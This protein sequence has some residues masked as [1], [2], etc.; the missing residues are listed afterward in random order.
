L[1][2][3]GPATR[4]TFFATVAS[5]ASI[6]TLPFK[7]SAAAIPDE[8]IPGVEFAFSAKVL[9]EPGREIGATPYGMRRRIAI[10]GGTFEGPMIKG[11]VIGGGA[12]WQLERADHYTL[13][14]ADYMIEADDGTQIHVRN[15]GLTNSRV[16]GVKSRYLR[17][18][19]VFEAPDGPHAWLNQSVFVG[20]LQSVSGGPPSVIVHVFRLT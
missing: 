6:L 13:I 2:I 19:P 8:A 5:A 1:D 20:S 17:T 12:D 14:E 10:I 4:R 18:V 3:T 11:R 9:L 7:A 16:P 15:T